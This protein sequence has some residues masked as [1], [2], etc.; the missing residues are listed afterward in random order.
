[1]DN[2]K[3]QN[4][5][6]V[7]ITIAAFDGFSDESESNYSDR[8]CR[9]LPWDLEN[10]R[11]LTGR[12]RPPTVITKTAAGD[13]V[14]GIHAVGYGRRRAIGDLVRHLATAGLSVIGVSSDT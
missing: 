10:T 2:T 8:I 4:L 11:K 13:Y 9:L 3:L 5:Y 12:F 6:P 1:M 14:I 7:T